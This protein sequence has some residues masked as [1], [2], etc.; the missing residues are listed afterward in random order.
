VAILGVDFNDEQA[1]VDHRYFLRRV[2]LISCRSADQ[3]AAVGALLRQGAVLHHADLVFAYPG[4]ISP[5]NG[6][7]R[8]ERILGV[9]CALFF[10]KKAGDQYEPGTDWEP[11]V[12]R[13]SPH[14]VSVITELGP[15]YIAAFSALLKRAREEGW[16]VWHLPF[17]P[18][19]DRFARHFFGALVD[20][21][22]PYSPN[23]R[24]MLLLMR[25]CER[26]LPTRFHSLVMALITQTPVLPFCYA[27]KSQHVFNSLG[28]PEV[29]K[30]T[31][32]DLL[33]GA[34]VLLEVWNHPVTVP[35]ERLE[36]AAK[37]VQATLELALAR[38][39]H[40]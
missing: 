37:K 4:G 8:R 39:R 24:R 9:N 26:I 15:K 19:D 13:R 10:W 6:A 17:S 1:V 32:A 38:V 18:E 35:L 27:E 28:V 3:A 7:T 25:H 12:R 33:G 14:L 22:W 36:E 31:S 2:S 16:Q 40:E 23:P 21:Y 34:G 29:R 30:I 20:K 11:E 5:N